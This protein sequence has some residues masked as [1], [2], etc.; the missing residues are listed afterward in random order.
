MC[1]FVNPIVS[2]LSELTQTFSM[3]INACSL[4]E[5]IFSCSWPKDLINQNL[6]K[7]CRFWV[8]KYID[9]YFRFIR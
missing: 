9:D 4:R 3:I 7:Q 2:L 6:H 8:A 1:F 5:K